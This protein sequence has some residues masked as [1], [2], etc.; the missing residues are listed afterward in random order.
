MNYVYLVLAVISLGLLGVLHKV[1]DHRTCRPE[2]IN[3]FLFAWAALI[4]GAASILRLWP[5]T[6]LAVPPAAL[7]V[8][9]VCGACA[10]VAIL[11][12]QRAVR[13]GRISTSWLIINLSAIVPTLLSIGIYREQISPRRGISLLLAL[14]ALLMLWLERRQEELTH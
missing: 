14:A 9:A 3:V 6:A 1:A 8:A 5:K 2:A 11:Y 4:L 13:H 10:S 12:F 7:W